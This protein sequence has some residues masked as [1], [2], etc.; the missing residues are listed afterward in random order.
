MIAR[1]LLHICTLPA[2]CAVLVD[3]VVPRKNQTLSSV[4]SLF[5]IFDPSPTCS[6]P[7]QMHL[8]ASCSQTSLT[9]PSHSP[10][11]IPHVLSFHLR[12]G[13][14]NPPFV[15][16]CLARPQTRSPIH[17]VCPPLPRLPTS[18]PVHPTRSPPHRLVVCGS[19][20]LT[21]PVGSCCSLRT[22]PSV[23]AVARAPR[24]RPPKHP[25]RSMTPREAGL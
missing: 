24:P 8:Y 9:D 18:R 17:L 3:M 14:N 21:S 22:G 2:S 20:S 6:Q 10:H 23:S 25:S 13:L 5:V 11:L 7:Y 15:R 16:Y 1:L 4:L 12:P 19:P